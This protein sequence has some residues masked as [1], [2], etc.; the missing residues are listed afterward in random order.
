MYTLSFG[1][2]HQTGDDAVGFESRFRSGSEAYL[3]EDYQFSQRLLGMII[4]RGYAWDTKKGKEVFLLRPDEV[5][6]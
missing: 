3:A 4:G 5:G 6:S 1:G 2:L